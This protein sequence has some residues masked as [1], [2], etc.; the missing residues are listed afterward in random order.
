MK[1]VNRVSAFFLAALA[2]VLVVYSGLFY[3]IVR[4]LLVQQFDQ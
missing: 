1:L 2:V 4:G 3:A